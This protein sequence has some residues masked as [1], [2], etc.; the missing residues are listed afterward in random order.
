MSEVGAAG[1]RQFDALVRSLRQQG[2]CNLIS[3]ELAGLVPAEQLERDRAEHAAYS[4]SHGLRHEQKLLP[5][6]GLPYVITQRAYEQATDKLRRLFPV[7]ERVIDL[8]LEDPAAREFFRLAPRHERLIRMGAAYRPRIQYCRYDFTL[9][10]GATPRIYELNTHC[11]A[12]AVFSYH[13]GQMQAHSRSLARLRELGLHPVQPPLER[14]GAFARAMLA[15]AERAGYLREGRNVAVLNSRY[16]TMNAELDLI[17]EQFRE[18]GCTTVRCHVEELGFDGRRLRHGE[19]PIHLT[20]NKYDDSHGP[21]AYECAFSRTTAEVQP[22]LDAYQ[23]GAVFSVNSFPSMYLT[24]QKSTLAFLWSPLLWKHLG[25]EE[26]SL[27]EE[28]VP[29]TRLVRHLKPEELAEAV[30][31]RE[32]YV[33]KR[34]L[35]TR[36]R[37]VQ[38]G[39]STSEA[40]WRDTL[41][42][43]RELPLGDDYVLQELA[44]SEPSTMHL[45]GAPEPVYTSLACFLFG[46]EP[47]GLIVRTSVEETTNVGRRGFMQPLL[48]VEEP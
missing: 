12:S 7:L 5:F 37:S 21:D 46:G 4:E 15:S 20:Y 9:G 32:R 34:S 30:A 36:G 48:L 16:L 27:I 41:A 44:L 10:P 40:E 18:Q 29:R 11:P 31:G 47:V 35:D 26:I 24:E 3:G 22:Y 6:Q 2:R 17:A 14:K 13:L 8:Y 23:A 25:R 19:L 42:A 1:N 33:L 39:R 28:I 43:A 45:S 38:L